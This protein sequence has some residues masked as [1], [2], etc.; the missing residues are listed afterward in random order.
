MPFHHRVRLWQTATVAVIMQASV[1]SCIASTSSLSHLLL[2]RSVS[3]LAQ[4]A[5]AARRAS[6][7]Q[8]KSRLPRRLAAPRSPLLHARTYATNESKRALRDAAASASEP[9]LSIPGNIPREDYATPAMYSLG[10]MGRALLLA[11]VRMIA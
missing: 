9:P 8:K 6:I 2:P 4:E 7:R 10:I 5:T 1:R 11:R 3:S